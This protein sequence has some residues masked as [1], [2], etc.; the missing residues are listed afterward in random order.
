VKLE[1]NLM[2]LGKYLLFTRD[3]TAL[4][5]AYLRVVISSTVPGS[6]RDGAIQ[7]AW[8]RSGGALIPELAP[9]SERRGRGTGSG[10]NSGPMSTPIR[11]EHPPRAPAPET[12]LRTDGTGRTVPE[13]KPSTTTTTT[14]EVAAIPVVLPANPDRE[15]WFPY[16]LSL[17]D[18]VPW[19]GLLCVLVVA[20]ALWLARRTVP[21]GF[22]GDS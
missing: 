4:Y 15:S 10:P 22:G 21:T 13:Q 12:G 1:R 20:I 19:L 16:Q 7:I 18:V 11:R 5:T 3:P 9:I 2:T 17:P 14:K 8:R 6:H